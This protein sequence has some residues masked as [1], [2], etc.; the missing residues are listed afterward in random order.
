MS[1]SL[2]LSLCFP[3]STHPR[4]QSAFVPSASMV[5]LDHLSLTLSLRLPTLS[6][7][8]QYPPLRQILDDER[9]IKLRDVQRLHGRQVSASSRTHISVCTSMSICHACMCAPWCCV[10][11]LAVSLMAMPVFCVYDRCHVRECRNLFLSLSVSLSLPA[12]DTRVLS[13]L[14]LLWSL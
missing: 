6:L 14:L 2:S 13:S 11:S 9:G 3:L 1:E 12:L 7:L 5:P 10:F 4:Y 8:V